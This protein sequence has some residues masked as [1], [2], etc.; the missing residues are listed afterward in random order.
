MNLPL[1]LAIIAVMSFLSFLSMGLDK[2]AARRGARRIPERWLFAPALLG[3][4]LGGTIGMFVFRHKT[5][6]WYF[7]LGFPLITAAQMLVVFSFFIY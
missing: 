2:A 4:A 5:R 1:L 7:R 3:G 6:H